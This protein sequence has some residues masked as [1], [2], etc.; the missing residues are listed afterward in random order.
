MCVSQT[1]QLAGFG[2]LQDEVIYVEYS[3]ARLIEL[4]LSSQQIARVLEG[5]NLVLPA[6]S[7]SS[8]SRRIEVRPLAA[9]DSI[10]AI[11]DLVI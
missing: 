5:Q 9:V 8:N 6:G 10:Q 11:E 4:G 1:K 3:P 2:R 7:I